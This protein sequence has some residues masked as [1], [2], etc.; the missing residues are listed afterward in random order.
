MSQ[1]SVRQAARR[2]ALD[3]QAVL[4]KNAPTGKRR[5]EA[6]VV[7]VLTALG[8][9]DGAVRHAGVVRWL[10]AAGDDR[11][12]GSVGSRGRRLVRQRRHGAGGDSAAPASAPG[13]G[14]GY[15]VNARR[16]SAAGLV[17]HRA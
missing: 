17:A 8:E 5:L 10:R 2:S 13:F 7:D 12:L 14:P 6:W 1:Q 4:R 9:R 3:A 16:A 11:R 15:T